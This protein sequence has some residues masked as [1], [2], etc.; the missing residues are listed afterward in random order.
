MFKLVLVAYLLVIVTGEDENGRK[1]TRLNCPS[2]DGCLKQKVYEIQSKSVEK[3]R[4][5]ANL[6]ARLDQLEELDTLDDDKDEEIASLTERV[7][8]I[9]GAIASKPLEGNTEK[10]EKI[11]NLTRRLEEL[12]ST[13][14]FSQQLLTTQ[15]TQLIELTDGLLA[16]VQNKTS[17]VTSE[18]M[19][20][21]EAI[22][23]GLRFFWDRTYRS[24]ETALTGLLPSQVESG[25]YICNLL[26][27]MTGIGIHE[28]NSELDWDEGFFLANHLKCL[29]KGANVTMKW[30]GLQNV[31]EVHGMDYLMCT[32][33]PN[34]VGEQS[35][36][37]TIFLDEERR[38]HFVSGVGNN[39][40][41]ENIR[42][43]ICALNKDVK[44]LSPRNQ[45]YYSTPST[46]PSP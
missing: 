24:V 2:N 32:N 39:C 15:L 45:Y 31:N 12:E 18:V 43:A 23:A 7:K 9:E 21:E 41:D 40:I 20:S 16:Q 17:K 29:R 11:A 13:V 42:I 14:R 37:Q 33:I 4:K 35:G 46:T 22:G 30:N 27:G 6:T 25:D 8:Q 34:K 36:S 10:D 26:C 38:Y 28:G 1:C 5:I 44:Y 19:P 3:D